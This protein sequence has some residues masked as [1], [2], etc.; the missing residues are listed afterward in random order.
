MRNYRS[1]WISDL[2][3]GTRGCQADRVLDFLRSTHSGRL[4]L[5]GD[6]VDGWALARSWHWPESHNTVV[7]K[8]LR[9]ARHGTRVTFVPGNHDEFARQFRGL[10]FGG[11]DIVRETIHVTA[12]GQCLLVMHGDEFDGALSLAPWISKLGATIYGAALL[13]NRPLNRF[14]RS[15]GRPYWSLARFLKDNTKQAV[16]YIARFEEAVAMR[17]R[18]ASVDGVV[19]GHIHK[20]EMRTIDGVLYLN[21]GDWVE[22]CTALVE[23]HDGSLEL[24]HWPE[25]T[26]SVDP[27]LTES[28]P[29][30]DGLPAEAAIARLASG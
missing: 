22:S 7:Q 1:I 20:A 15:F 16:K 2:H 25:R 21:C 6:V 12:A 28:A 5:V 18:A 13:M 10:S 27:I 14:R 8:I 29:E 9:K 3:L 11:I 26:V 17:A 24:I 4:Y 30:G 23:H 19:C